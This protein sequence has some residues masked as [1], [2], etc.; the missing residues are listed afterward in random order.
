[1]YVRTVHAWA[2]TV[3][4]GVE[5]LLLRNRPRSRLP[6]G[7]PSGRDPRVCLGIDKP[8]KTPLVD[9]EPKRGE[10][11]KKREAKLELLL[12]HKV[13]MRSKVDWI[14]CGGFNQS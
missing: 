1:V 12:M 3:H 8:P 10:E 5:G 2:R 13:K 9:I 4:D 11:S 14:D 7:T 6:G